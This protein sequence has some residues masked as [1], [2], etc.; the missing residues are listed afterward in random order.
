MSP[1]PLPFISHPP[2]RGCRQNYLIDMGWLLTL[3]VTYLIGGLTFLPGV[4]ILIIYLHPILKESS[5]DDGS[6]SDSS[7][8]DDDNENPIKAGEIE[9][10]KKSGLDAYKAGWIIVTQDYLESTDD[11]TSS[12]QS[13]SESNENKSA[14]S[15]LYKLVQK[16]NN[17]KI[18]KSESIDLT[19][20]NTITNDNNNDLDSLNDTIST[21]PTTAST[22][23]STTNN[24][25]PQ[26]Q[27]SS[28]TP[29]KQ[30]HKKHRYYGVLK[31]GNLFLYKDETIKDVKHVIVL[32]NHFIT[33][34]P[35]ELTDGQLFTKSSSI[36]LINSNKLSSIEET[37]STSSREAAPKG[38]FFLY[39]DV[40]I[41]KEDW[42]F[43]LIRATKTSELHESLNPK[44]YAKTLHFKTSHMI[45]LIQS[46]YSSEG[47]L[48]TKWLNAIIGR[49]FL[50]FQ[51]TK[52]LE[53][54]LYTRISKKLNKIKKPG[55]LDKFQITS[56]YP[57]DS[58]PFLTYPSL[59][60]ISPDGTILVST[61]FSYHGNLSLKIATKANIN[62]GG[63]IKTREVD[64]LLS[65]T[66]SKL[67]GPILI[68]MK[69]PPSERIWYTFSSEPI[70]NLK[71]EPIISQRQFTYNLITNSIE[72]KLKE[73]VKESLV[74]PHWDD[75]V[76]YNTIDEIYKGG[77]WDPSERQSFFTNQNPDP[78]PNTNADSASINLNSNNGVDLDNQSIYSKSES[79]NDDIEEK[80]ELSNRSSRSAASTRL[81]NTLSDL[82]KRLKKKT[83]SSSTIETLNIENHNVTPTPTRS[84]NNPP[85]STTT[86]VNGTTTM[87]TLKRIGKWYFKDDKVNQDDNYTPPE[88]ISNRR[89]PKKHIDAP[90]LT[91]SSPV[92]EISKTPSPK[93]FP[94]YDFGKSGYPESVFSNGGSAT[95]EKTSSISRKVSSSTISSSINEKQSV[96]EVPALPPR[97]E[98]VTDLIS[99]TSEKLKDTNENVSNK[100]AEVQAWLILKLLVLIRLIMDY[101]KVIV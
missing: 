27:P 40:N 76:F 2:Y 49:L 26:Q 3:L 84:N 92:Q 19:T 98:E 77:I 61:Y 6:K 51:N 94:S 72:K 70:L 36:A 54:Y 60:E 16:D 58:A 87:N 14:Y 73:A 81:T 91:T 88:M 47:Q 50:A 57:G 100:A 69:P 90:S 21:T 93:N 63:R 52:V 82:S 18:Q 9:E 29:T 46:L 13:V 32:S 56:L 78:I 1:P 10:D 86:N 74:L 35:R 80:S 38:S 71:I 66:L 4:L 45:N 83:S 5:A 22:T 25:P 43:T 37:A 67:E 39:C 65:I 89:A 95:I 12:T 55:F 99:L 79:L 42:Y 30:S 62:L 44:I 59:K 28:T 7:H 101:I 75:I 11:I 24:L 23:S 64:L 96:Y 33:I 85:A 53:D 48:Q 41:D 34:W 97:E 15:S 8:N 20:D 17:E 31:H 68:K